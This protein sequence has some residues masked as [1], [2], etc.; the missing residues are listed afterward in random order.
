MLHLL[1]LPEVDSVV[2]VRSDGHISWHGIT[3]FKC[4]EAW[5][6]SMHLLFHHVDIG[7]NLTVDLLEHPTS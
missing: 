1:R 7:L 6:V 5:R 2:M 3:F 4:M